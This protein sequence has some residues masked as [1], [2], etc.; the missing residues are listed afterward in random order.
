M[1]GPEAFEHVI[2]LFKEVPRYSVK[3]SILLLKPAPSNHWLKTKIFESR[4]SGLEVKKHTFF[5]W[6]LHFLIYT[7]FFFFC[8]QQFWPHHMSLL[9]FYSLYSSCFCS[10]SVKDGLYISN[11]RHGKCFIEKILSRPGNVLFKG[12]K[13]PF[14]KCNT[15]AGKHFYKWAWKTGWNIK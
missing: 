5:L 4:L 1:S 3:R 12:P 13:N 7:F 2:A 14:I 15:Q 11:G 8:G 6:V 9:C 10:C